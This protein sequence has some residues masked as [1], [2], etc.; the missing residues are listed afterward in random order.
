MEC[1]WVPG[2]RKGYGIAYQFQ[3]NAVIY[4]KFGAVLQMQHFTYYTVPAVLSEVC[5]LWPKQ[6]KLQDSQ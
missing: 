3:M 4:E 2:T 5:C 6:L 1:I